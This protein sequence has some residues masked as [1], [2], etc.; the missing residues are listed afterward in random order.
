MVKL[1]SIILNRFYLCFTIST[2]ISKLLSC[3][4]P[5]CS[6][7]EYLQLQIKKSKEMKKINFRPATFKHLPMLFAITGAS[8][9][10]LKALMVVVEGG[11]LDRLLSLYNPPGQSLSK[12]NE[13]KDAAKAIA[14][15]VATNTFGTYTIKL[16]VIHLLPIL[17]T[18]I[19]CI[20]MAQ[21][22]EIP[23]DHNIFSHTLG[24]IRYVYGAPYSTRTDT[25]KDS[26]PRKTVHQ[27]S[28]IGVGGRQNTHDA[29]CVHSTA[30]ILEMSYLILLF[31]SLVVLVLMIFD[32]IFQLIIFSFFMRYGNPHN[33]DSDDLTGFQYVFIFILQ[34][35]VEQVLMQDIWKSIDAWIVERGDT[36]AFPYLKGPLVNLEDSLV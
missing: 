4:I 24:L 23:F 32:K 5:L 13:R 27:Q 29:A 25:L 21:F 28:F 3:V 31:V 19:I 30:A 7:G 11:H 34:K 14:K 26:F 17:N 35:N 6:Q 36:K 9:W 33:L 10:V 22:L 18:V 2:S 12:E 20:V 8:F 15:H 16:I 1:R